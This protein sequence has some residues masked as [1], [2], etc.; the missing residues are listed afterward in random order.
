MVQHYSYQKWIWMFRAGRYT[1]KSIHKALSNV[2]YGLIKPLQHQQSLTKTSRLVSPD[3]RR[4]PMPDSSETSLIFD[5]CSLTRSWTLK[6]SNPRNAL[7]SLPLSPLSPPSSGSTNL[8]VNGKLWRTLSMFHARP[9]TVGTWASPLRGTS[10]PP[11]AQ[12]GLERLLS[13]R[14]A[15][16]FLAASPRAA[17]H[18]R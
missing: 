14:L 18:K 8:K 13:W 3:P 15:P 16:R 2:L 9:L 17:A 10:G 4:P 6:H 5:I 11:R 12:L 1:V 7:K